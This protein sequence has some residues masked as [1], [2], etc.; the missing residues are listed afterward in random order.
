MVED[1]D[2]VLRRAHYLPINEMGLALFDGQ[3]MGKRGQVYHSVS[4]RK[5]VLDR[6][7]LHSRNLNRI[8]RGPW[9]VAMRNFEQGSR[10]RRDEAHIHIIL[11]GG[12]VNCS[13]ATLYHPRLV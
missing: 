13:M 4:R 2:D 11:D 7:R 12:L 9:T 3:M 10:I 1:N 6:G 8:P 5:L